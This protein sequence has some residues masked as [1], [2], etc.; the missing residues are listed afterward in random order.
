MN[1]LASEVCKYWRFGRCARGE[2]CFY[3]HD[4]VFLGVDRS[5]AGGSSVLMNHTGL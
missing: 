5:A 4:P 1:V 2:T 3:K